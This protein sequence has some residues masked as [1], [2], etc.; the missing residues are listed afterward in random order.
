[1]AR[2][3][4]ED[5][6]NKIDKDNLFTEYITN[7]RTVK[8]CCAIFCVGQTMLMRI[9]KHYDIRKPKDAHVQNIKKSKLEHFGNPNYNNHAKRTQTNLEK[10]G[11]ENQ[12]QRKELF[13]QIAQVKIDRYGTYNNTAKNHA[14]R[15]ANSGSLEASYSKQ[16]ETYKQTCLERYNTD[17]AAKLFSV[18]QQIAE[19]LRETF[20]ERYGVENYWAMPDAK[21]SSGSKNSKAN[22]NFCEILTKFKLAFV[23]EFSLGGKRFDFKVK[24]TLIEINPTA[25]HNSTWGI[26]S[27]EGLEKNY[28]KIKTSIA[29]ANGL[30]CIH[31]FDW[32]DPNK[33]VM[34]LNSKEV[35]FGRNCT[36]KE[37]S[38]EEAAEFLVK[39]HIQGYARDRI[40]IGL[41][42]DNKLVSLMTFGKPRYNKSYQYE[43]IRYCNAEFNIVGGAEKLFNY[44]VST[45]QPNSVISYCDLS[46]FSGQVYEKLEFKKIRTSGAA[47]H[48]YNLKTKVHVTDN[49]LRQRGFD[50]L[51]KTNHG[52][53]TSNE[54]LMLEAGF[55]EV[56]DCGQATY[57]WKAA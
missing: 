17:N 43:L 42:Y 30:R 44:F 6:L 22:L 27:V 32:D 8:E 45:Y 20:L 56:Y 46:K 18:R 47:K 12:F 2:L 41:Y 25:T 1:M 33:I 9:L 28:H 29:N 40:R 36:I 13:P 54:V 51:F 23:Q 5:Y 52:K 57:V 21:L 15:I 48:W 26:Y 49:L 10:Y 50:Q 39:Y 34:M 38:A 11:V 35:V 19:S 16:I 53:G 31:V 14:T 37:V 7:N 3:L 4:F 55:V 24:D